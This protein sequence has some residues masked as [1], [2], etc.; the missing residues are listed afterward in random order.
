MFAYFLLMGEVSGQLNGSHKNAFAHDSDIIT[1]CTFG[2]DNAVPFLASIL[3]ISS[4]CPLYKPF[5][6]YFVNYFYHLNGSKFS[7][8]RDHAIWATDIIKQKNA[9]SDLVRLFLALIDVRHQV[10]NFDTEQFISFYNNNI[11]FLQ[12]YII[13]PLKTLKKPEK[14]VIDNQII[15]T[16][17]HFLTKQH[18]AL[19][20]NHYMPHLAAKFILAWQEIMKSYDKNNSQYFWLIKGFILLAY[21]FMP[22]F[23]EIIWHALGYEGKP[24]IYYFDLIPSNSLHELSH[25]KMTALSSNQ[26]IDNNPLQKINIKKTNTDS[27]KKISCC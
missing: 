3:G 24:I 7:T 13:N 20:V 19:Q 10:G 26:L 2:I 17:N 12:D 8:S 4:N 18:H 23:S 25:L 15:E 22:E 16:L 5:D 6:Y 1:I 11:H 14:S 27:H 9:Q 21:P